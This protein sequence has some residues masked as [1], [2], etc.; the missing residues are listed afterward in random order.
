[1]GSILTEARGQ[2]INKIV[3]V[4]PCPDTCPDKSHQEKDASGNIKNPPGD[5]AGGGSHACRYTCGHVIQR[6]GL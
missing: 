6:A 3:E 4:K 2:G 5:L 1:M